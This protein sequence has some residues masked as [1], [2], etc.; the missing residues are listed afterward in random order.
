MGDRGQRRSV[1]WIGSVVVFLSTSAACGGGPATTPHTL[2]SGRTIKIISVGQMNFQ[3]SGPAL[4]LSYQ[5]DLKVSQTQ[6]LEKEVADVWKDFQLE[7]DKAKLGSAIIM[8]NEV[9]TG[10]FIQQGQSFNFV[11][12]RKP[13]GSWPRELTKH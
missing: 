3:K 1:G 6:E 5:T 8:A 12:T 2:S 10:R 13:D 11:F 4:V 7:V 9:P